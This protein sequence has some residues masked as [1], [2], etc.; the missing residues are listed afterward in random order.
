[1]YNASGRARQSASLRNGILRQ[2]AQAFTAAMAAKQPPTVPL[3]VA[4]RCSKAWNSQTE[5][6]NPVTPAR[7]APSTVSRLSPL[8]LPPNTESGIITMTATQSTTL[9]VGRSRCPICVDGYKN[10]PLV[11]HS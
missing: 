10:L 8:V 9:K 4:C 11:P 1:M 2:T 5:I 6:A 3:P 7:S